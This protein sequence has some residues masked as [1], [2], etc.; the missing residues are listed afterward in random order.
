MRVVF[1]GRAIELAG[2]VVKPDLQGQ[3][4]GVAM[5]NAYFD[6]RPSGSIVTA[7]TRNP[8]LA[9][10]VERIAEGG[11]YPFDNNDELR[12][13]ATS[14]PHATIGGNAVYHRDRYDEGGLFHGVD[15][16]EDTR[17]GPS[18]VQRFPE[19]LSNVRN[20]LVIAAKTRKKRGLL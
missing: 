8:S 15:P 11:I 14:M 13:I 5:L 19:E 4:I 7:Y 12:H 10:A 18:F 20:A 6:S 9:G 16:A 1:G 3:G 2:Q 17:S